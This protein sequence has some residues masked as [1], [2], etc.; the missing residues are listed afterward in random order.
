MAGITERGGIDMVGRLTTGGRA[1]VATGTGT[2]HMTMI[3]RTARHR[4]PR[5]RPGLMAGIAGVGTID[6]VS[7][8]ATRRRTIMTTG[9]DTQY[10]AVINS[11]GSYRR[12]TRREYIVTDFADI[13]GTDVASWLRVT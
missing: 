7:W 9:T 2:D 4:C 8:F 12:P 13:G 1:I 11:A 10:L 3:D 5:Y 6:M